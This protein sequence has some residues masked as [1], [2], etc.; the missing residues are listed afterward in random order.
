LES[1]AFL[2]LAKPELACNQNP[3]P[4]SRTSVNNL[5]VANQSEEHAEIE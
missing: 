1:D 3:K 5:D 4:Q 2:D